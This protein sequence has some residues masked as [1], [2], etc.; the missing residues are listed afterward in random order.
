MAARGD[1][2]GPQAAVFSKAAL[3]SSIEL[4][5]VGV[6]AEDRDWHGHQPLVIDVHVDELAEELVLRAGVP[7]HGLSGSAGTAFVRWSPPTAFESPCK[8]RLGVHDE[9]AQPPVGAPQFPHRR[10]V[11]RIPS[12]EDPGEH[13]ETLVCCLRFG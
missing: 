2:F 13:T 8:L 5:R 3:A 1:E 7:Q 11:V 12:V 10:V 4:S 9:L 6:A